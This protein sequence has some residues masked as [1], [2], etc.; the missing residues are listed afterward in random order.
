MYLGTIMIYAL[1]CFFDTANKGGIRKFISKIPQ[2]YCM[3]YEFLW[4]NL[5]KKISNQLKATTCP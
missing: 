1:N 2:V 5:L 4:E 3:R